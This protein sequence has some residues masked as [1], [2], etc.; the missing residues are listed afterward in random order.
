MTETVAAIMAD[1]APSVG[2][3]LRRRVAQSQSKPSLKYRGADDS[4]QTMTWLEVE[5]LAHEVAAG[6][7][8]LGVKHEDRVGI[9]SNTRVEWIMAD[10]G[11]MCAAG[12]TTTVYPTTKGEDVAYILSDADVQVL[13]AENAEQTEKVLAEREHHNV[14]AIIQIDGTHDDPLVH[15][16]DELLQ[17]GRDHLRENPGAVDE[18]INSTT[19][20][21][22][23][24]LIYTSGTTGRPKGVRLTHGSWIYE[25]AGVRSV[26]IINEDDVHFMWL[27]LSHVF[28]KCLITIWL[29]SGMLTAV[30]GDLTRIVQGLGEIQ[31]T[32]MA[33]APR[34]FEKVRNTVM[35]GNSKGIKSV[36]AR[37]AFSVGQRTI[38]YRLENK[39]VP[40]LLAT[41]YKI[42]DKLVFSKLKAR[43][44]GR[45]KFFVSG[46]A[47][48]NAQVQKWFWAAG[49]NLI[50]G[51]G[52][53][54]T[55]AIT[56]VNDYRKPALGTVGPVLPGTETKIAD[57]GEILVR[58]PGVM[59]GY[60]KLP[61]VT[62]EA[63][64]DDGWF[65]TGDIGEL[66]A[67]GNLR[68]TDRKKDLIKT[69][70]GKYVAPQKVEGA[71]L[72]NCPYV[73]QAVVT[74]EGRKYISALIVLDPDAIATWGAERGYEGM[75][76]AELSQL[77]HTRRMVSNYIDRANE[78]LERW[79]TVKRFSILDNELTID[80][81]EV[82]PSLK[83]RRVAVEE[84]YADTIDE[85]YADADVVT[86]APA[87]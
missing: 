58:G 71:I 74:G 73:S 27:P 82:T 49:I 8:S 22:L 55:S 25:G 86:D 29:D 77:E 2:E 45:V 69:S 65:R 46:S 36:I 15:S 80:D 67:H 56:F 13:F 35:I 44:G 34:I 12:A 47:K 21:S 24:T 6:L 62:A 23:S 30:D 26:G 48:L 54:E 33:G 32:V 9:A 42:A 40:G 52:L 28:G 14:R 20:E 18:A 53:T 83:V 66:D 70:G 10:L 11:V 76:Y 59:A 38:P 75:P 57:D 39:P 19:Q 60:E 7:I 78:R 81:G 31:P 4:W 3:L 50:E 87:S 1:S 5:E 41:Q 84:K 63:L 61:E 72:A 43:M 64:T 37:W 51:Y 16:W 79:E 85:M 17:R 68:I